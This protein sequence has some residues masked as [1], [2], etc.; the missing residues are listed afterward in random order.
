MTG[1]DHYREAE[2]IMR[3]MTIIEDGRTQELALPEALAA[4]QVH[5]ILALAGATGVKA[6]GAEG[7]AWGEAAGVPRGRLPI[8]VALGAGA[9]GGS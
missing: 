2:R 5:A 9:V 3:E 4:A 8:T 7:R 6:T 1:P